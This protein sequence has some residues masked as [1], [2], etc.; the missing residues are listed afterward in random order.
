MS[1]STTSSSNIVID[2]FKKSKVWA[3]V[4]LLLDCWSWSWEKNKGNINKKTQEIPYCSSYLLLCPTPRLQDSTEVLYSFLIQCKS[5]LMW[6]YHFDHRSLTLEIWL[7]LNETSPEE[8]TSNRQW[9][10]IR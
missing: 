1:T 8:R 6:S 3:D 5:H 10:K 9:T 7:P 4:I 2:G